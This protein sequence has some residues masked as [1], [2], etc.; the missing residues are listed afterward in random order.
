VPT[1]SLYNHFASKE[2]LYAAVLE[3][4]IGPVLAILAE[5]AGDG[6]RRDSGQ[7]VADL[8]AVLARHPN[9]PRLV[10]HEQLA[11]GERLTPMLRS[12]VAPALARAREIVEARP[13]SR[14]WRPEQ[15]PLLVL[16]MYNVVVG[17]FTAAAFYAEMSGDDLL[18][19]PALQR[20]SSFLRQL[21]AQLF[22]DEPDA[23]ER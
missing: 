11:G 15:I 5:S 8:M 22:P 14:R 2:S 23:P 7:L 10:L 3:R 19:E 21:V 20:Q 18:T 16:A 6:T 4:G 9:L 13:P 12:W 1:P 17:Y